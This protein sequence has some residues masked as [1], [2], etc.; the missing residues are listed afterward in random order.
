M[1]EE[2]KQ[3]P[4]SEDAGEGDK[5]ES[6]EI[7]KRQSERIK[8]LE[9]EKA[10]RIEADAKKQLGGDSEAGKE[11]KKPK[12]TPEEIAS[13]KRIKSIGDATGSAWAKKYE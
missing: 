6:T 8:E 4:T 9:K 1:D 5:S 11:A 13:R 12:F 3:E 7:I 2:N 10:E